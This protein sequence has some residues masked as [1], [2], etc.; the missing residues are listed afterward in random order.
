MD[1]KHSN[2]GGIEVAVIA[3]V[4]Q[5]G[6]EELSRNH[7]LPKQ[8]STKGLNILTC[9]ETLN[10][11]I[12]IIILEHKKLVYQPLEAKYLQEK[13]LWCKIQSDG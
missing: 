13:R 8:I 4:S 7:E 2:D 11:I 10:I 1:G 3:G 6:C 5:R 9:S 12:V